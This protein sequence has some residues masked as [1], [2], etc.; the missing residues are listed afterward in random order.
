MAL[1]AYILSLILCIICILSYLILHKQLV[2]VE[3]T[4]LSHYLA[5]KDNEVSAKDLIKSPAVKKG[6]DEQ[7]Q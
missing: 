7:K 6:E 2:R 1:F 3:W 5:I 4:M